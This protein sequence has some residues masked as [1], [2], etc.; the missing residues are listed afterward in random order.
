MISRPKSI[1][2]WGG[3]EP[4]LNGTRGEHN[5]LGYSAFKKRIDPNRKH[6]IPKPVIAEDFGVSKQTIYDWIKRDKVIP[7]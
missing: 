4:Y 3:V 5:G 6:K 2:D 1:D 7:D